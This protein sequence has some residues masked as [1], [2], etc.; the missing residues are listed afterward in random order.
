MQTSQFLKNAQNSQELASR[1]FPNEQWIPTE[2]NIWVA[3]S[4][5]IEESREPDKWEREMSQVRILTGRGSIAYF[6]P[7]KTMRGKSSMLCADLV[8]DGTVTEMKTTS[9]TR[10]T[11][12]T[13]FRFAYKQGIVLLKNHPGI[14]EHSVFIRLLSDFSVGSVK[15]KIA[16]ELK[17]RQDTGQFICYFEHSGELRVW[18]YDELKG[19][20][21][22]EG[23]KSPGPA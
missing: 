5:L 17:G 9:G 10:A 11:L 12:G 1:L 21:G 4:R 2:A 20:I 18:S 19:M 23:K 13:S 22:R 7:E 14:T 16:G 6:L 15:A 8:L 3:E